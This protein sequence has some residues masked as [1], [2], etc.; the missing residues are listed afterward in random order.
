MRYGPE[1][2]FRYVQ[3]V[4]NDGR[5]PTLRMLAKLCRCTLEEALQACLANKHLIA[6]VAPGSSSVGSY[7]LVP[8]RDDS[9]DW[10]LMA[11]GGFNEWQTE[12]LVQV[13]SQPEAVESEVPVTEPTVA[14][15]EP[16]PEPAKEHPAI[17]WFRDALGLQLPVGQDLFFPRHPYSLP[18]SA[19]APVLNANPG[20]KTKAASQVVS[21]HDL[22]CSLMAQGIAHRRL[23]ILLGDESSRVPPADPKFV[24][25]RHEGRKYLLASAAAVTPERIRGTYRHLKGR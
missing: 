16:E 13:E 22:M 5:V 24:T 19:V 17:Q 7:I 4:W 10:A 2:N 12:G 20:W 18:L 25:I 23:N 11:Q 14:E 21:V 3:K 8:L 1:E 6:Y 9:P 15:P